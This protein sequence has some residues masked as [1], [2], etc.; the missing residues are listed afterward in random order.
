MVRTTS[1]DEFPDGWSEDK[2]VFNGVTEAAHLYKVKGR[3]E[4]HMIYELNQEGSRS[5]G[6]AT[7]ENLAG[8]WEKVTDRFATGQQLRYRADK[9]K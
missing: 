5:F 9:Q 3:N 8:P 6:L 1:L 7:A 4:Y 2:K